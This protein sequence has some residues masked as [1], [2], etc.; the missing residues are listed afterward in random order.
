MTIQRCNGHYEGEL[1]LSEGQSQFLHEI[2][3]LAE[4]LWDR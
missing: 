4:L 1:D 2:A 3:L